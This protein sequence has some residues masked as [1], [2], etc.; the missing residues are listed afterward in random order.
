MVDGELWLRNG[1]ESVVSVSEFTDVA[2]ILALVSFCALE[3]SLLQVE[4]HTPRVVT[5]SMVDQ[6]F[7]LW[8]SILCAQ[9]TICF[10]PYIYK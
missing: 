7:E 4:A 10:E 6:C 8:Y 1:G 5:L 9:S 3:R 2:E